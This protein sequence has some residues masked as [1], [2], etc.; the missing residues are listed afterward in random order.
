[1][2]GQNLFVLVSIMENSL[3]GHWSFRADDEAS[4]ARHMLRH[5]WQYEDVFCR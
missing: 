4:V 2:N 3:M 5:S 1:M